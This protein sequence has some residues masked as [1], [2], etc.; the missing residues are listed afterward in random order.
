[1]G[2]NVSERDV[3]D[4]VKGYYPDED[5]WELAQKEGLSFLDLKRA[6]N[7][8][9]V[10]AEAYRLSLSDLAKLNFP[11]LVHLDKGGYK[12]FSVVK[13]V[14][15]GR[16]W[17]ADPIRGNARD[18]VERFSGEWSGVVLLVWDPL[19]PPSLESDLAFS[20]DVG[21]SEDDIR[22]GVL[23]GSASTQVTYS[24]FLR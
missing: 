20:R 7:D 23:R 19:S 3:L 24:P 18:S 6:A 14:S 5:S 15:Q 22:R 4:V 12:H 9:G 10:S 1:L 2:K 8:F 21:L 11:V 16:V 17:L 13:G